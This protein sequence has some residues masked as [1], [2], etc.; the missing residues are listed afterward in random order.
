LHQCHSPDYRHAN[1]Q[2]PE[3]LHA[4]EIVLEKATQEMDKTHP[5]IVRTAE[6]IRAE[7][8][9]SPGLRLRRTQ[10][11]R[12]WRLDTPTSEAVLA[13]LE[14]AGILRCTRD[15]YYVRADSGDRLPASAFGHRPRRLALD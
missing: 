6:L 5:S 9:E 15:G 12:L 2:A 11:E 10:V 4:A 1:R 14:D 3:L 8:R 13:A 7:Y